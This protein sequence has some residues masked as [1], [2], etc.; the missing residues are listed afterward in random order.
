MRYC[1]ALR[2]PAVTIFASVELPEGERSRMA[3]MSVAGTRQ[4]EAQAP[5]DRSVSG[6]SAHPLAAP[7]QILMRSSDP[8]GWPNL[9]QRV[10]VEPL[11]ERE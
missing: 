3:W 6:R 8:G 9:T 5:A 1:P 2:L 10:A 7:T 4:S 11:A